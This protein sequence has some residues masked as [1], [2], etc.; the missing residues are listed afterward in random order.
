MSLLLAL[1]GAVVEPP[2]PLE[3][4]IP[5]SGGRRRLDPM[6][7]MFEIEQQAKQEAAARDMQDIQDIVAALFAFERIF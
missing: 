2:E 7:T 3:P 4:T 5:R 1:A 6:P